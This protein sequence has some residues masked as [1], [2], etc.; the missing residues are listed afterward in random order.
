MGTNSQKPCYRANLELLAYF[1]RT[2]VLNLN[3][4]TLGSRGDRT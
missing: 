2:F 3:E 1:P 4:S